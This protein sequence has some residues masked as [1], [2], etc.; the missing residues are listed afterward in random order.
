MFDPLNIEDLSEDRAVLLRPPS[1]TRPAVWLIEEDGVRAVIKDFMANGFFYRNTFGRFLVWREAKALRRLKG[2]KG[3]PGLFKVLGGL[4]L[5]IEEIPGSTMKQVQNKK[6][7]PDG[8]FDALKALV[9]RFH[10]KGMAHCD[11][12]KAENILLGEDG[13]PYVI[14]WAASISRNEFCLP[15]LN[16]IYRRFLKDDY[17]AITKRKLVH[18]PELVSPEERNAYF[19]Q[20][21][22]E[23]VIR[24]FRDRL[25]ALLK[26]VA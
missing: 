5:V 12:K 7:L 17:D 3:V 18:S 24:A 6:R 23:R 1:N 16:M 4:S 10:E 21:M 26:K 20:S 11:L 9:D 13:R 8:F 2:L 25:R 14:D 15:L 22:A 19:Y